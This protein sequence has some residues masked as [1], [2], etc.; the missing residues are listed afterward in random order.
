MDYQKHYDLL[1]STRKAMNRVKNKQ[2]HYDKHHIIP[3]SLGGDNSKENLV[4]L[5]PREHFLAHFLL[6]RIHR[7]RSMAAAF[8]SM[9]NG[10]LRRAHGK[11]FY[12]A[13]S[14]AY[15]EAV[16]AVRS[17]PM[18]EEIRKKH[19][20]IPWNKGRK[21]TNEQKANM[22]G[23]SL[24][25]PEQKAKRSSS[26]KGIIPSNAKK[27][28]IDGISYISIMDASRK[29]TLHRNIIYKWLHSNDY[30]NCY[31]G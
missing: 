29:L 16:E 15:A 21:Y 19:S 7:N 1:M 4:L 13:S 23:K 31:F 14:R 20:K 3:K 24:E 2:T 10:K 27:I 17:I 18:P 25:T 22:K 12:H 6:W 26:L 11:D 9:V 30:A 28:M 8:F 5:T